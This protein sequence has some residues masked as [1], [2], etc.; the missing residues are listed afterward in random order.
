M[1]QGS[2]LELMQSVAR[3]AYRIHLTSRKEV[4]LDSFNS[5]DSLQSESFGIYLIW[6]KRVIWVSFNLKHG[7]HLGFISAEARESFGIYLIYK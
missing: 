6:C 1:N 5:L 3:K 4:L 7:S 2:H